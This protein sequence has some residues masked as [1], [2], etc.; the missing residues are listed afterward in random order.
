MKEAGGAADP[1]ELRIYFG[2]DGGPCL[3]QDDAEGCVSGMVRDVMMAV[4][5]ERAAFEG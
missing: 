2:F 1:M 4:L 5:G 3:A